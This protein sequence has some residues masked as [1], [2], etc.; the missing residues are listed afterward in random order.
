MTFIAKALVSMAALAAVSAQA[1]QGLY[2]G[3]SIGSSHYSE[4][5]GG[6]STDRTSNGGKL[7]GGYSFTPNFGLELGYADVG[8]FNSAAGEVKG[9]GVFLDAV[10]TLPFTPNFSGIARVGAFNGKTETNFAGS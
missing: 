10:G 9:T 3:G 7:Y 8:K 6:L 5:I 2:L 1:Q 4:D